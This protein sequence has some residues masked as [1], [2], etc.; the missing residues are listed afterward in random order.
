MI[1]Q[2]IR[3]S[4][5]LVI[6]CTLVLGG[7]T[8]CDQEA[9]VEVEE[10]ND[11]IPA[12]ERSV[13]STDDMQDKRLNA[14]GLPLDL[15]S[16]VYSTDQYAVP[17]DI[18]NQVQSRAPDGYKVPS[19]RPDIQLQDQSVGTEAEPSQD[20]RDQAVDASTVDFD[21]QVDPDNT[22]PAVEHSSAPTSGGWT[23]YLG[24]YVDPNSF[25]SRV[26]MGSN[27][28]TTKNVSY[29]DVIG[30]SYVDFFP[31]YIGYDYSFDGRFAGVSATLNYQTNTWYSQRGNH[32]V[33]DESADYPNGYV[34]IQDWS[35]AW[36]YTWSF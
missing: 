15:E 31:A 24:S 36:E 7:L 13:E 29:L 20:I 30:S 10:G 16:G 28:R 14:F 17:E 9:P 4:F 3:R 22:V 26:W 25:L 6:A 5:A 34:R 32:L 2:S 18:T 11:Q 19:T 21:A 33:Y 27:T 1:I 12:P 8:G 35:G 23:A